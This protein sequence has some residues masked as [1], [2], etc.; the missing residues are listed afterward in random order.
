MCADESVFVTEEKRNDGEMPSVASSVHMHLLLS[1]FDLLV[2]RQRVTKDDH[3]RF[4]SC[5][6]T[7]PAR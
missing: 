5:P 6:L 1:R 2:A 7:G 3:R 4:I